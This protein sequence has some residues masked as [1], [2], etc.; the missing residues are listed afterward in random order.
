MSPRSDVQEFFDSARS[1]GATDEVIVALLRGRGWPEE[2]VYRA[3]AD[4]YEVRSGHP[5]PVYKRSGSAKDAFLYLLSFATLATWALGLGQAAFSLIDRWIN[6]PVSPSNYYASPYDQLAGSLAC[7]IVAFP[8]YLL[9]MRFIAR[10]LKTSPEKLE[11]GVR[12]WLTYI[13]LLI[14]AGI[15]VGDLITFL[16]FFLRGELTARFVAKVLTAL[17]IAGGVFWYYLDS[18][19]KRAPLR[20]NGDE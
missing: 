9:T 12:K 18:L 6:D 1:Q 11:S 10:E 15:L 13:A 17:V 7:I 5:V 4:H 3:L 20:K 19:A 2:D 16:T 8:V 14:A